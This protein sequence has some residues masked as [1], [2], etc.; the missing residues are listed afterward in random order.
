ME[1]APQ[2][3]MKAFSTIDYSRSIACREDAMAVLKHFDSRITELEVMARSRPRNPEQCQE[4]L[5]E[6]KRDLA[7]CLWHL[8]NR[9]R[10][11]IKTDIEARFVFPAIRGC[12][13]FLTIRVNS[14]PGPDWSSKLFYV[15]VDLAWGLTELGD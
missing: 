11:G 8:E 12:K 9:E 7:Q 2:Q 1:T 10:L 5:R 14:R 15:R 6:L 4:L 13:A 3:S